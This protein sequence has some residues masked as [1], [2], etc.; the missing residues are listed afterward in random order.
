MDLG[1]W[2]H[3]HSI[4][5]RLAV[6][7]DLPDRREPVLDFF[8]RLRREFPSFVRMHRDDRLHVLESTR[9]GAESMLVGLL[10]TEVWSAHANPATPED[11]YRL[12]ATVLDVAPM[13]LSITPIDVESLELTFAFQ[14]E[15]E[16]NRDELVAEA[17]LGDSPLASMMGGGGSRSDG[18]RRGQT[19]L[20][21][22]QPFAS[23]EV[24]RKRGLHA[25]LE[26]R[27]RTGDAGDGEPSG[28][29]FVDLTVRRTG[30]VRAVEELPGVMEMLRTEG[31]EL[32]AS[33]LV[34]TVLNPLRQAVGLGSI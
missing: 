3:H 31:E 4:Q 13:Y 28:P 12:H 25:M 7:M 1:I 19:R 20:V 14:F 9:V 30:S 2:A 33:R 34:P 23:L 6:R 21:D 24:D 10:A 17:L 5:Q 8:D 32:V 15:A 29:I 22:C 16:G 26:V 11:A 27:T 18:T